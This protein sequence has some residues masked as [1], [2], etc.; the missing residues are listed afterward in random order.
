MS[1]A[2][3]TLPCLKE[4]NM[5]HPWKKHNEPSF[6]LFRVQMEYLYLHNEKTKYFFITKDFVTTDKY[7]TYS[8]DCFLN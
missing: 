5:C 7:I 3:T 2:T 6:T 8:D 4:H 1:G